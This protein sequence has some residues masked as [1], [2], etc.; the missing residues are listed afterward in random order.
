M[1]DLKN[2][3]F[4]ARLRFALAGLAHALAAERSVRTQL[5]ALAAVVG[6]LLYLRPAPVWWA[7]ILLTSSTV[8]AAELFNTALETL[9]DHLHPELHP[10][11]R[12]V[13]DCAAAAVLVLALGALCVAAAL[14][15][16]LLAAGPRA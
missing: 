10:Q 6:A 12:I 8:I 13:K 1:T 11:I 9:A 2:K 4:A 14:L 16:S 15:M 5:L 3:S 7:L